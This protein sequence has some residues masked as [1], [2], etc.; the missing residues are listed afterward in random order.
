MNIDQDVYRCALEHIVKFGDTDIFPY[1]FELKF[2][3]AYRDKIIQDLSSIDLTEYNPMS[4]IETLIPKTKFG[5]RVAHQP[6]PIDTIIFTALVMKIFDAVEAGRDDPGNNRAF[7]YRKSLGLNPDL[8]LSN[9]TYKDWLS[10]LGAHVFDVEFSHAIRTDISDFYSRIYRHRLENILDSLSGDTKFVKKIEKFIADWRSHQSFGLPVG[11]NAARLLAEAALNDMDMALI[12]EGYEHTRYVDDIV[13]FIREGQDPYG[14]L[15]FLA[16]HLSANEGLS[17]N[18]QKTRVLEWG[19]FISS[20]REPAAE[21]EEA[22]DGFATEKLFWLAY[23]HDELGEEALEALATKDLRKELDDLLAEQYW[24]MGAIRIVLHAMRLVRG[25]EVAKYIREK[26]AELVPFAKDVCLL[27]EE[28]VKSGV[29][30]FENMAGEVTE[31]LL[32]P[33]MKPLDCARAWFLELAIRKIVT[34]DASDVR[35]L[36]ALSGTLDIRQLHL[37]RWRIADQNYFRSRKS[38]VSEIQ[39]WAQPSFIFGASCLP[40]DEYSH[41]IRGIKSRLQFPLAR[42]FA[43]WCLASHGNNPLG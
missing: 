5:F 11:S 38:R 40:R 18:N 10:F 39:A 13:V 25:P 16:N 37:I 8:F 26:L 7:S 14:A 1:P 15:A 41:W 9:H 2:I 43:D 34:F 6:Y 31:L 21:D 42:E 20:V 23:G 33:R 36:D 17:L 22:K 28:F 29:Q 35:R 30:G 3:D 32:S 4:L 12:A 24:D 19:E 27:I